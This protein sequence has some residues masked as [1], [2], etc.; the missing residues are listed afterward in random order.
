MKKTKGVIN[1]QE[2]GTLPEKLEGKIK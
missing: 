1:V 2:S